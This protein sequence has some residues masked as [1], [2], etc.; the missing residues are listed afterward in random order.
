MG[1]EERFIELEYGHGRK[2]Y[3][4]N[5]GMEERFVMLEYGHGRKVYRVGIWACKKGL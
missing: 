4:L 5:M 1:M 2:V 3:S